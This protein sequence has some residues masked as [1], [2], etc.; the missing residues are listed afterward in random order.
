MHNADSRVITSS[1]LPFICPNEFSS[2]TVH[3]QSISLIANILS[4][5]SSNPNY[6][7]NFI[8]V[9]ITDHRV[10]ISVLN[11]FEMSGLGSFVTNCLVKN[12]GKNM[13]VSADVS[14]N[15]YVLSKL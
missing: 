4:F 6:K 12:M 3:I 15:Y 14:M 2:Q 13:F 9:Y 1:I 5:I 8:V 10:A 7:L 11:Q